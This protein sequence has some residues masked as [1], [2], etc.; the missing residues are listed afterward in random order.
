MEAH[1]DAIADALIDLNPTMAAAAD[2]EGGRAALR[3]GFLM[4]IDQW[5]AIDDPL[6][7]EPADMVAESLIPRFIQLAKEQMAERL[8]AKAKTPRE[9]TEAAFAAG[10]R[11]PYR[12]GDC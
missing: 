7:D 8:I 11:P 1:R 4:Q 9:A 2:Q 5:V 3:G 12:G 6:W 10:L